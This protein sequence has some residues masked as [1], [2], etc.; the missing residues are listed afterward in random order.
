[1]DPLSNE[2]THFSVNLMIYFLFDLW[3]ERKSKR[4]CQVAVGGN[5]SIKTTFLAT[6]IRN[7]F[8]S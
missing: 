1:M 5:F 3:Q 6:F 4:Y 7:Y 8:Q 2:L